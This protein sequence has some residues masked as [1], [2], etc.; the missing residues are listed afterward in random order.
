MYART[1][2]TIVLLAGLNF[3]FSETV[4]LRDKTSITG[5]I[6]AEKKEQLVVDLGFTV[7]VVPRN[8]VSKISRENSHE[9]AAA[10]P[11]KFSAPSPVAVPPLA[12]PP[13]PSVSPGELPNDL[14][15]TS[16]TPL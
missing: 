11:T 2:T 4:Q 8:Q 16:K 15:Q 6:L 13:M 5:K 9:A 12:V 1:T 14:F 3:G 7:L 10:V